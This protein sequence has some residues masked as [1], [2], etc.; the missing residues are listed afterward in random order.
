MLKASLLKGDSKCD[1]LVELLFYDSKPVYFI[2]NACENIRWKQKNQRLW[3][4]EMGGGVNAPFYH[5]N[6]VDEYN[7]G[8]GNVD[9]EDQLRL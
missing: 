5:L 6:L 1:G 2:S 9:Q 7:L 3:H 8:T 4:K